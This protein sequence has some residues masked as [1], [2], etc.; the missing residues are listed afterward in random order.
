MTS[1]GVIMSGAIDLA[2][3][4]EHSHDGCS[5]QGIASSTSHSSVLVYS[6]SRSASNNGKC[7]RVN[8]RFCVASG[9]HHV[10][11]CR[12]FFCTLEKLCRSLARQRRNGTAVER[13]R[14]ERLTQEL[15]RG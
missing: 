10:H 1:K 9:V 14:F 3:R 15:Q 13:R 2:A 5:Q 11:S 7:K 4:S 6:L 12:A 8:G